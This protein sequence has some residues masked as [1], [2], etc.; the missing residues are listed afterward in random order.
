MAS[1][2]SIVLP[3]LFNYGDR[4]YNNVYKDA[5]SFVR[6]EGKSDLFLTMIMDVNCPEV[7]AKLKPGQLPF[8]RPDLLCRVFEMKRNKFM[9]M[10]L[11]KVVR[12][13]YLARQLL[14]LQ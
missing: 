12:A 8:D 5:I 2:G 4:W 10:I 1:S 3:A 13:L 9:S 14:M 6:S 7:N 11:G